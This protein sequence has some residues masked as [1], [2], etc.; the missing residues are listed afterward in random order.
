M[1]FMV[2]RRKERHRRWQLFKC[3]R[4]P[5]KNN[6]CGNSLLFNRAQTTSI[7]MCTTWGKIVHTTAL[8]QASTSSDNHGWANV[9]SRPHDGPKNQESPY[10]Y[11][12]FLVLMTAVWLYTRYV[13]LRNKGDRKTPLTINTNFG[14]DFYMCLVDA[15]N[16]GGRKTPKIRTRTRSRVYNSFIFRLPGRYLP[17][18][19]TAVIKLT[20]CLSPWNEFRGP[21][22]LQ[23]MPYRGHSCQSIQGVY[24]SFIFGLPRFTWS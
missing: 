6:C 20:H 15:R 1:V 19:H 13:L 23:T 24:I 2:K 22:F 10:P 8:R 7:R 4:V 3:E 5:V 9:V 12:Q 17:Y 14:S 11:T 18:I 21:I 16:R